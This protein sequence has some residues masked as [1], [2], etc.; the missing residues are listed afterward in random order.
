MRERVDHR[1]FVALILEKLPQ[2]VRCHLYMQKSEDEELTVPSLRQ[3]LGKYIC[4]LEMAGSDN[5]DEQTATNNS[6]CL[7]SR[8]RLTYPRS[9]TEG[10]FVTTNNAQ[11]HCVYCNKSHWSHQCPTYVTLQVRKEKLRGCCYNC[12]KKGHTL[13][14]CLKDRP[15][16]HCGKKEKSS[17]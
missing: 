4:A 14:D 6:T 7:P 2:K 11:N 12:L 9:T 1:H 3:L 16:A 10:L 17:P 13:K 15:C 5:P 8:N